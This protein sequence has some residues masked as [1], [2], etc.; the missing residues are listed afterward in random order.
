MSL[1]LMFYWACSI[2]INGTTCGGLCRFNLNHALCLKVTT[3]KYRVQKHSNVCLLA[4]TN[5]LIDSNATHSTEH[6]WKQCC[7]WVAPYL[8]MLECRKTSRPSQ[9]VTWTPG[10]MQSSYAP[11]EPHTNRDEI[12][13]CILPYLQHQWLFVVKSLRVHIFW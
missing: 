8:C 6:K 4:T 2:W 3:I 5:C 10:N 13:F 9:A 11:W 12:F 1:L 7:V